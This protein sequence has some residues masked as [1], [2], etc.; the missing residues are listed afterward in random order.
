M[1]RALLAL[2]TILVSHSVYAALLEPQV[3]Q[4]E[5]AIYVNMLKTNR[6]A[7]QA[8]L[9]TR[10]YLS[11]CR[12]VVANPERALDLVPE[13]DTYN[14]QYVTSAEQ[15]IV[16]KAITMNIAAMMRRR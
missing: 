4:Q 5:R 13:P 6:T 14:V 11:L 15:T 2:V 1:F 9:A 3:P 10:E 12:Q 16:D 8:Y 7:A